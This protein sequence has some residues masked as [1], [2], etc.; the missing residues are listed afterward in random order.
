MDGGGGEA[1]TLSAT[2]LSKGPAVGRE[3]AVGGRAG[4]SSA[5][6]GC[7]GVALTHGWWATALRF[8]RRQNG[9][10]AL[11]LT[12]PVLHGGVGGPYLCEAD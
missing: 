12:V 1:K 7:A 8:S 5:S 10:R 2:V 6:L 4:A 9:P 3:W 11:M